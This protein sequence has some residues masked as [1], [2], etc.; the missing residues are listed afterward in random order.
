MWRGQKKL[1]LIVVPLTGVSCDENNVY[2]Q[3]QLYFDQLN[4]VIQIF[5]ALKECVCIS[6][7]I[8]NK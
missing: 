1:I 8:V 5:I 6:S 2:V 3:E 7:I 4:R